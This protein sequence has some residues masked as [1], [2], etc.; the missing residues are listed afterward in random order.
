[1]VRDDCSTCSIHFFLDFDFV[2]LV[3]PLSMKPKLALM[4]ADEIMHL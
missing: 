2:V 3:F 4:L 1:M